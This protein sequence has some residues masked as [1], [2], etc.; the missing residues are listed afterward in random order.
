MGDS[1]GSAP[2]G[3]KRMERWYL[4]KPIGPSFFRWKGEY[5]PQARG[6]K[7][8]GISEIFPLPSTV[9]GALAH[10]QVEQKGPNSPDKALGEDFEMWGPLIYVKG[11]KRCAAVHAYPGGMILVHLDEKKFEFI[12]AFKEAL[13]LQRVGVALD[14]NTKAAMEGRLYSAMMFDLRSIFKKCDADGSDVFGYAVK[15]YGSGLPEPN[16][17]IKFGGEGRLAEVL[18]LRQEDAGALKGLEP[19]VGSEEAL[20]LASP[21]PM[22]VSVYNEI[23]PKIQEA[24]VKEEI[25]YYS[26]GAAPQLEFRDLPSQ[27]KTELEKLKFSR[28]AY[29]GSVGTGYDMAKNARRPLYPA[30]MPGSI[31]VSKSQ[32]ERMTLTKDPLVTCC[33]GSLIRLP[34]LS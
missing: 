27:L 8:L 30:L 5:S 33:W 29:I 34:D 26:P 14:Y 16:A 20:L 7:A 18:E 12:D 10:L 4:F 19:N 6:P 21:A 13:V 31:I 9:A 3:V 23:L 24:S 25:L 22:D 28:V 11:K 1:K 15:A 32:S 2:A 17:I